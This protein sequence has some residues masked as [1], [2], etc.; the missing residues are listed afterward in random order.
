MVQIKSHQTLE[1]SCRFL[2][3]VCVVLASAGKC[4]TECHSYSIGMEYNN[5]IF[6]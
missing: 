3:C 2:G 1:L 5:R 6:I 4:I